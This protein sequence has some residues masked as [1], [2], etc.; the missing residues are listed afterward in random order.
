ML[1]ADKPKEE[2]GLFGI[3]APEQEVAQLT[4]YGLYALQHRGQESAGIA[5]SEGRKS[6]SYKGMG[7]VMKFSYRRSCKIPGVKMAIGMS[8]IQRPVP[9]CWPMPNLWLCFFRRG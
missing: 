5:V 3:F 6:N 9:V 2:C 1:F 8:G 4:Y 7:L